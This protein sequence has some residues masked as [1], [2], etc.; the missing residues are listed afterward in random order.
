VVVREV[1]PGSVVVGAPG[2][3]TLRNGQRVGGGIDLNQ[4]DLPD[5]VAR[6]L[7]QLLDRI[8]LLEAEVERL[9]KAS[10]TAG[11]RDRG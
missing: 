2:R 8:H 7:E 5:P 10:E 11:A 4:V 3:M 6:A 1:P 9:K